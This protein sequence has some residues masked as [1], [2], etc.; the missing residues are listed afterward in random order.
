MT[1]ADLRLPLRR[2]P[3][4]R[5]LWVSNALGDVG[6][7][8]A[9]LALSVTAVVALHAGAF[10]VAVI[11]A[12]GNGAY[13]FL[14]VPAGVWADRIPAKRLLVTADL[15]RF[16]AIG[17]VPV[18]Y[19]AHTLT[20]PHLMVAAAVTSAANVVFEV[21]HTTALPP[22]VGRDR[23]AHASAALQGADSTVNV[24]G[25][26][27]AGW[28]IALT[29]GP[30]AFIVTAVMHLGSSISAALISTPRTQVQASAHPP[31]WS[32]LRTGVTFVFRTPLQR[33][34]VLAAATINFGAGFIA[35]SYALFALRTLR[36]SAGEYGVILAIGA[37]GGILASLVA[38]RVRRAI[39]EI[40]T[41]LI[42]Y[43]L[44]PV[45]FAPA[46]LAQHLP[47]PPAVSMTVAEFLL[48]LIIVVAAISSAGVY[49]RITP[50]ALF[51]RATAARRTITMGVLPLGTLLGGVLGGSIG[52]APTLWVGTGVIACSVLVLAT[53][54]IIG[55]R[56]L[57]TDLNLPD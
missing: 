43:A 30:I 9:S 34:F 4:F 54:P 25:P 20:V 52:Y 47:V 55:W 18:A 21:A 45:A 5:K 27:I 49:P 33:T 7:A 16:F 57:P 11:T 32:S 38:M 56:D 40:R 28:L 2:I 14:G 26:G 24:V 23:V 35:A 10:E 15:A 50:A 48:N 39:G 12:L 8:F 3:D 31:F 44:I 53:S 13:L 19:L 51:G 22:V 46:P 41:Q 42:C 17:S 36:L 1:A 29:S 37:V 6:A